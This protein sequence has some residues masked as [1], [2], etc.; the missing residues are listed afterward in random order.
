MVPL[1]PNSQGALS[2]YLSAN[3]VEHPGVYHEVKQG[4]TLWVLLELMESC[5]NP[6]TSESN[7]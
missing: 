3:K 1:P 6:G 2:F 7:C 5:T 4:Q